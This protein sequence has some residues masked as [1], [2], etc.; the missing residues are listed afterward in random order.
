MLVPRAR[1]AAGQY[2]VT[3]GWMGGLQGAPGWRGAG[4]RSVEHARA[5]PMP[6]PFASDHPPASARPL[7]AP[8]VVGSAD[9]S[10]YKL[11]VEKNERQ[12]AL[13]A[14]ERAA[15]QQVRCQPWRRL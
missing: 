10:S 7:T 3:G 1:V 2:L 5:A 6:A 11:T 9:A 4:E 14:G 12:I 15:L 8:A 13:D